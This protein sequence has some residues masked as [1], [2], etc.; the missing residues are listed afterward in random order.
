MLIHFTFS[1][2]FF[3]QL[4]LP[5]LFCIALVSC[6]PF[7]SSISP[8]FFSQACPPNSLSSLIMGTVNPLVVG[9][10]SHRALWSFTGNRQSNCH[11]IRRFVS[12]L[13]WRMLKEEYSVLTCSYVL[14]FKK[15]HTCIQASVVLFL[16]KYPLDLCNGELIIEPNQMSLNALHGFLLARKIF[17]LFSST[18]TD[19]KCFI[20]VLIQ[21]MLFHLVKLKMI[22]KQEIW[23]YE[24]WFSMCHSLAMTWNVMKWFSRL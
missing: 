12:C 7:F 17:S 2:P 16:T 20:D 21:T 13:L 14:A 4:P 9:A 1:F 15:T 11:S 10:Q 24:Y 3:R 23:T 22:M 8:S 5:L 18:A 19:W 6:F